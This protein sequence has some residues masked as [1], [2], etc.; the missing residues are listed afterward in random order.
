M[1][2]GSPVT[3]PLTWGM[4]RPVVMLPANSSE[5]PETQ[6]RAVLLHELAQ[7][8][9]YDWFLQSCGELARSLYWFHPLACMAARNLRRESERACDD[10][11]L[12]SGM[13]A[14]EYAG[15]LLDLARTLENADRHWSA[16]LAIA[17]TS[18]L[19][20]RFIA[21]LNPSMNRGRLSRKAGVLTTV[22][23]MCFL[24]PF[25]ALRLPAQEGSEA[26]G[27][28]IHDPS[29][30]AV[31]NATVVM[32]NQKSNA[33]AMT[34][35]D[36]AGNFSFKAL[37]SGEYEMKVE[38]RGFEA[39]RVPRVVLDRGRE[40]SQ[41]VTLAVAGTAEEV[42]VMATR[43][44]AVAGGSEAEKK[45]PRV[46]I[47]GDLQA[48][49]ILDKKM[50][51]YPAGAKAAGVQ[52]TVILHAIIGMDGKPLSLRVMNEQ[53]DPELARAALEAASQWRYQPTL[54]NGQPIEVDTT[55]HVNFTLMSS[56]LQRPRLRCSGSPDDYWVR[57]GGIGIGILNV[58]QATPIPPSQVVG[59]KVQP[60][61]WPWQPAAQNMKPSIPFVVP[62]PLGG[63]VSTKVA[64]DFW[65]EV[66][67]VA[68]F[69][70]AAISQ[71]LP[72]NLAGASGGT[73]VTP[74]T[75]CDQ[76]VSSAETVVFCEATMALA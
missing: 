10:A 76:P 2:S 23:A 58:V 49:K 36:A 59:G 37:P 31:K 43:T 72:V 50:P 4:F 16:G 32:T 25:T 5:W 57:S 14:R 8:A 3:M 67:N 55:I 70:C 44:G 71:R 63:M 45:A 53:I 60:V 39:Y 75:C 34:V 1:D 21:M 30:A 28:S 6:R 47:G 64:A 68:Q 33:V 48:A 38:K 20:R 17:R 15:Q 12:T 42:D 65:S 62:G 27:G 7:V 54:L 51:V 61:P 26:F 13:D 40:I 69:G 29:G 73:P 66:L 41:N 22:V 11:V 9:R 18:T 35:S 56:R 74:L 24:I 52:G 19:E 46:K